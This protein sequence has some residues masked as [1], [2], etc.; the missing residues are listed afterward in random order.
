MKSVPTAIIEAS[1]FGLR[2]SKAGPES[3]QEAGADDVWK[4]ME[5]VESDSDVN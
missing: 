4:E 1:S 2:S 5:D 3:G